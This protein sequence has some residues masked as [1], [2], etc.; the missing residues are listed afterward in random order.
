MNKHPATY[1]IKYI[2][3][4]YPSYTDDDVLKI[5]RDWGFLDPKEMS[6][7]ALLKN[8][9]EP[10][11]DFDP[12][13][14]LHRPSMKF[15]RSEKVYEMFMPNA[16]MHDAWAILADP[17]KRLLAEH[18]LLSRLDLTMACKKINQEQNLDF[19]VRA[20]ELFKHYFWNISLLTF[21]E[22][23]RYLYGRCSLYERYM[24][25]LQA[26]KE[27]SMYHLRLDQTIES[28][29]MLQNAQKI[30]YYNLLEVAQKPGTPIEKIKSIGVL[31]KSLTDC[32]KSLSTSDN[33]LKEI[34]KQFEQFRINH[35]EIPPPDIK[36]LAPH[37]NYSLSGV[38]E[39][40]KEKEAEHHG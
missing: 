24:G 23:G 39:K 37:G 18:L 29:T 8:D 32:H 5:I 17:E 9:L 40:E 12:T 13:N 36:K 35:P 22:W 28:N 34:L 1:F 26:P 38:Q 25:L 10:P 11:T 3:L 27:L 4:A 31:T 2:I 33:A 30:C 7:F 14:I 6:F 21:D 20:L 16:E 19:T 15:L